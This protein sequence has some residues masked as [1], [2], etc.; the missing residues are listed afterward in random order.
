MAGITVPVRIDG[1]YLTIKCIDRIE[2]AINQDKEQ[3]DDYREGATT[4]CEMLKKG[5]RKLKDNL[6]EVKA[7]EIKIKYHDGMEEWQ[8]EKHD[9]GD[10][11]DLRAAED[12]E[13]KSGDFKLVS[14]GVSMQLPAGY[15]AQLVPRS[16]TFKN[17]GIIMSN[18]IGIIDNSYCGDNDIWRFPAIAMRNTVIHKG[19]RIAQF[20]IVSNQDAVDFVRVDSLGNEN[21]GGIGS[22]GIK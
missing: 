11:I 16:S 17:F 19:D 5:L 4:V 3:S 14:L 22:T 7:M 12:I 21:R 20:R 1:V 9:K 13:M 15:H 8:I 18:S 10:W 6:T 2:T